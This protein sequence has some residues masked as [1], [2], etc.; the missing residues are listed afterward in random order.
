M[1][2]EMS[3]GSSSGLRTTAA[4][5]ARQRRSRYGQS[6]VGND[7]ESACTH[8]QI[9]LRFVVGLTFLLMLMDHWIDHFLPSHLESVVLVD[10]S[11]D[12]SGALT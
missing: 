10:G 4:V 3:R 9:L 1:K 11:L 7:L 6:E 12:R 8:D 5:G 2:A